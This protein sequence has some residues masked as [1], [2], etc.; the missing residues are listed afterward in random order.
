V[1]TQYILHAGFRAICKYHV[2]GK[3]KARRFFNPGRFLAKKQLSTYIYFSSP[4]STFAPFGP[5]A[6]FALCAAGI[7]SSNCTRTVGFLLKWQPPN[8]DSLDTSSSTSRCPV[9]L[10]IV[11]ALRTHI[12]SSCTFSTSL[13]AFICVLTSV[14]SASIIPASLLHAPYF[15][16]VS[17]IAELPN[18]V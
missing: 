14:M 17:I 12:E 8:D 18:C 1:P 7:K 11:L 10:S 6:T 3:N 13:T 4:F 2:A 9:F 15:R 5:V 16:W